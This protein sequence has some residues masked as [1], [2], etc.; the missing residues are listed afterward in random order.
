MKRI[1][2][3]LLIHLSLLTSLSAQDFSPDKINPYIDALP[4]KEKVDFIID[5]LYALYSASLD[6]AVAQSQT[7]VSIAQLN[8][9]KQ[10]EG[11]AYLCLG[12][13][14]YLRGDYPMALQSFLRSSDLF[15]SLD[16]QR[17]IARVNNEMAVFYR[18]QKEYD[19]AMACLDKAEA[20]AIKADDIEALGTNYGHRG[21]FLSTKGQYDEARPYFEKVMKI[22]TEQ[23]DS[24]GLG[25]VYLD[26]AEYA[27]YKK[28]YDEAF[29][30]IR[31]ST[32]IRKAIGD[33]QG[34]AVNTVII[35]EMYFSIEQYGRAIPYFEKTIE[36]ATP[37]AYTDLVKFSYGM[38]QKAYMELG[39]YKDAYTYQSKQM[40]LQDSLLNVEKAKAI[41]ELQTK[42]ET[43]KKEQQIAL[44]QVKIEA[45]E[46]KNSIN[47]LIITG[48]SIVLSLLVAIMMLL[49]NRS[50]RKEELLIKKA[51]LQLKEAEVEFSI[52]SQE[53]ERARFAKDLHDGFGQMISIL[54]L[55]LKSLEKDH[56]DRSEIFDNSV[57]VLD[58]MYQELKEI[59][60]NLMPQT[61]VQ[62][63]LVSAINE[64]ASR[65]NKSGRL[66]VE[67]DFFGVEERLT[68][69]QEISYYRIVQEWVNN[70]LKYGKADHITIQLT[71]DEEE[72]TLLIEDNGPGFDASVLTQSTKGNGWKNIQ[73]RTNLVRGEI[74]LDTHPERKGTTLII[75]SKAA[76]QL[77]FD[78]EKVLLGSEVS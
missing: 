51:E 6:N 63:G 20:A 55:N 53:R 33:D 7:A 14:K 22:R 13:S 9:W 56:P 76:Q 15:D 65:I 17:G 54:N 25:Y 69:V 74:A 24:V 30:W 38:L 60:F 41:V 49:R 59:C 40:L 73:S 57:Q 2:L 34:V 5:N 70:V 37:I 1:T 68:D 42:F 58:Q 8:G 77:K 26:M 75:I 21:A 78:K 10:E 66:M 28:Q 31:K 72:M 39:N 62:H 16:H 45:Q 4:E 50:K 52:R 32:D 12:V 23:N 19:K 18:K 46:A 71:R 11:Y 3:I 43:E 47:L 64:F 61:L 35:G 48:L 36:L 27:A 29:D 67:T 44:Q